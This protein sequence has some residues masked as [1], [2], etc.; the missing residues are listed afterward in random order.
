MAPLELKNIDLE[1]IEDMLFLVED[2]FN[3]KF[4]VDE[5]NYVTTFGQFTDHVANKISLTDTGGCTTQQAFYKLKLQLNNTNITPHS[6][7]VQILP[8]YKRI[9]M[10]NQMENALGFKLHLLRPHKFVIYLLRLTLLVSTLYLFINFPA[11]IACILTCLLLFIIAAKTGSEFTVNT[12]GETAK[13]IAQKSYHKA[14]L[15]PG[16]FNKVEVEQTLINLFS[17]ALNLPRTKLTRNAQF[18][19]GTGLN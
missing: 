8:L 15:Q 2:S 19:R 10:V 18:K 1:D 12:V 13:I 4:D 17:T 16:T 6:P 7:W 5:L 14:R 3:F 11:G 9:Y